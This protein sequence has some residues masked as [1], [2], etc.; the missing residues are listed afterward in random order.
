MNYWVKVEHSIGVDF[1]YNPLKRS[2]N[3]ET[4][5][6]RILRQSYL[7]LFLPIITYCSKKKKKKNG[8]EYCFLS[9]VRDRRR[10]G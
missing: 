2:K 3:K 5:C 7:L 4:S 6:V 8:V 9:S 1:S 10:K